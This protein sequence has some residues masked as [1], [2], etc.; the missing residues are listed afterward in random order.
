MDSITQASTLRELYLYKLF[1]FCTLSVCNNPP[2]YN[3]YINHFLISMC[4]YLIL[5][6]RI[7]FLLFFFACLLGPNFPMRVSKWMSSGIYLS[8]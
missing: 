3:A 4:M 8:S 2:S 5:Y 1:F 6:L 7:F